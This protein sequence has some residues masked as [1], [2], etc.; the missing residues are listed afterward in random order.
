MKREQ[1]LI[2]TIADDT[3]DVLREYHLGAEIAEFCTASNMDVDFA[4]A[5]ERLHLAVDG[6]PTPV[7]HGPFNELFPCAIDPRARALAAER[8]LQAIDLAQKYGSKKVVL[9]GG[10]NPWLYYPIW[11]KE[12]SILF[13]REFAAKIPENIT[14][15]VE[16]VLEEEPE[17]LLEIVRAVDSP[18]IKLCLDIGHVNAYS[19]I[20]VFDWLSSWGKEISHFHIHNNH[21]DRDSHSALFD[22][23]IDMA[24]FLQKATEVCPDATFAMELLSS[25]SS[26]EYLTEIGIL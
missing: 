12:Q 20:S 19:K 18:R 15:C 24:A 11:Y 10:Y 14:V 25:R 17:M 21:G 5:A 1:I 2:S 16:N 26:A 3:A 9:H 13:W 4:E 23:T 6:I 8:F 22:G 7:F